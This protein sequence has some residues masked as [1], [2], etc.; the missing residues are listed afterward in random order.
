M[1]EAKN[2]GP[3]IH[4][5]LQPGSLSEGSFTRF[6]LIAGQWILASVQSLNASFTEVLLRA[7]EGQAEA[8]VC[9][10]REV[11]WRDAHTAGGTTRRIASRLRSWNEPDHRQ[12]QLPGRKEQ[13]RSSPGPEA[14]R[15]HRPRDAA[16]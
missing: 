1:G 8:W 13:P 10:S 12:R 3:S 15:S 16:V 5:A 6:H 7:P 9:L 11:D 4:T 2:P 14:R